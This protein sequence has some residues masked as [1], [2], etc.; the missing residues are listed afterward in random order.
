MSLIRLVM[1]ASDNAV[2]GL[3]PSRSIPTILL[4]IA[5]GATG[6]KGFWEH[7][8][9]FDPTLGEHFQDNQDP[10]PLLEGIG[11]GLLVI[12]WEHKCIESFQEYQPVRTKG[13]AIS[14]DGI[15]SLED[16]TE[17]F[18]L[19]QGWHIIDHHFEETI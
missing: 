7:I 14:H 18:L 13:F 3:V 16:R 9:D 12:S 6:I 8:K 19:D 10:F 5:R 11:D 15:H 1:I 2:S 17:D 4:G